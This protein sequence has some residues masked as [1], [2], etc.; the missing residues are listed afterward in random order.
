MLDG[1]MCLRNR[2]CVKLPII[3]VRVRMETGPIFTPE[4]LKMM[5]SE[6]RQ[7][8]LLALEEGSSWKDLS[9]IRKNISQINEL[10]DSIAQNEGDGNSR[11][12]PAD[13]RGTPDQRSR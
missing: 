9:R 12:G 10:L 3:K 11:T 2:I 1:C 4:L 8:F 7:K 6:E 13:Q 5:L